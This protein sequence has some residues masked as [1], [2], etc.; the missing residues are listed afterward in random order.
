MQLIQK[1]PDHDT[2]LTAAGG[3]IATCSVVFNDDW[4][5]WSK[6]ESPVA[7]TQEIFIRGGAVPYILKAMT[8]FPDDKGTIIMGFISLAALAWQNKE[9]IALVVES[10]EMI[11]KALVRKFCVCVVFVYNAYIERNCARKHKIQKLKQQHTHTHNRTGQRRQQGSRRYVLWPACPGRPCQ[12]P[13][14]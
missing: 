5:E 1:H 11:D 7:E 13:R 12:F 4:S 14:E 2:L 6:F 10:I 8:R 9:G 3:F